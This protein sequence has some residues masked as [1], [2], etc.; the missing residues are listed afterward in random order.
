MRDTK[1]FNDGEG[2]QIIIS[3]VVEGSDTNKDKFLIDGNLVDN[4]KIDMG[5]CHKEKI[6]LF[7]IEKK[8]FFLV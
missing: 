4:F 5:K 1:V 7:V 3:T 8:E 6:N 2:R